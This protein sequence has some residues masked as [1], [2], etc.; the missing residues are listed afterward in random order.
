MQE[1]TFEQA[2]AKIEAKDSRYPRDAYFFIREAL[3]Y[4]QKNIAKDARGRIRHVTGQELLAGIRSFALEQFGPMAKT[5]LEEWGIR[6]CLDFGEI[7][8]NMVEVDWLAKTK[9]D[10]RADFE[11]GYDFDEAFVK[12][13]LPGS[14]QTV[15]SPK[16]KP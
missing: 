7:V 12:P 9:T 2:L 10:S 16:A 3:D 4:T 15:H 14:K 5:V 11:N 13:F 8:F 6:R 1:V